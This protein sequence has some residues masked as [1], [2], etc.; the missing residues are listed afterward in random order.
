MQDTEPSCTPKGVAV[1]KF[2][3]ACNRY[4]KQDNEF[5]KE[6][7]SFD[8]SAWTRLAEVC[9]KSLKKGRGV[10]VVEWLRQDR[11]TDQEGKGHSRVE[12]IAEHVE[13]KPQIN[14]D[15]DP[16]E[17]GEEKEVETSEQKE[18]EVKKAASF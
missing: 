7:S 9:G 1:C 15:K 6:A 3:V 8:V 12:I 14:K 5:Q 4:Y 2:S 11:W 10:R 17:H 16:P 18:E 13:F